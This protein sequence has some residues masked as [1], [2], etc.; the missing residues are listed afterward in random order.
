MRKVTIITVGFLALM[1]LAVGPVFAAKP[2][3]IEGRWVP[4]ST[5]TIV[6]PEHT[7]GGNHFDAFTNTGRY[8][9][10]PIRGNFEQTVTVTIHTGLPTF[11]E[12]PPFRFLWR[13]DRTIDATVNGQSGTVFM[14]L[15]CK[16]TTVIV[17]G[18]PATSFEG[19]WVII[20]ATDGLAGLHGQGTWWNVPGAGLAYEGQI[21]FSPQK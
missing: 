20:S 8:V 3:Q 9:T 18:A 16:G 5:M 15:L 4:T 11:V 7:A 1:L 6:G 12:E 14:R 13:I 10:G 19:T 17:D 21:N 2:T